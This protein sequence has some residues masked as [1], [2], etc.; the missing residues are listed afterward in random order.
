MDYASAEGN[1][2]GCLWEMEDIHSHLSNCHCWSSELLYN[3][4]VLDVVACRGY[5]A[6]GKLLEVGNECHFM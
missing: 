3:W 4:F 5:L 2:S 1:I 6:C